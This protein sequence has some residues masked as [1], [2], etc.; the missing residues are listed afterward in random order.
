MKK[1]VIEKGLLDMDAQPKISIVTISY[2]QG[3]FLEQAI[4]SVINQDYSNI[5]YIVVDPGSTDGSRE[6]IERYRDKIDKIIFEPDQGP[7]DGLNKGFHC[8]TGQIYGFLNSDDRL[9]PGA[10]LKVV[11]FF[12]CHPHADVVSGHGYIIDEAGK[13]TRK[14]YSD[15]FSPRRFAYGACQLLQQATFFRS[16]IFHHVGGFNF[17]NRGCWDGELWADFTLSEAVFFRINNFLGEFRMHEN[18]ISGSAHWN[19]EKYSGRAKIFLK[20]MRRRPRRSD[21][22]FRFLYRCEKYILNPSAFFE[23]IFQGSTLHHLRKKNI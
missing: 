4:Q 14:F 9:L 12:E 3:R 6:I 7:A 20:L 8:A 11:N 17:D 15:P 10:L 16:S 21:M 5:E 13:R 2:N 1:D 23:R 18:C 22:V 19:V